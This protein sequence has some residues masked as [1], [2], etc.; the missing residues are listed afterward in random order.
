MSANNRDFNKLYREFTDVYELGELANPNDKLNVKSYIRN[1]ILIEKLQE[2]I[3]K[4]LEAQNVLDNIG[5]I[6]KL[7]D[8]LRDMS[9]QNLALERT[10]GI[11]RKSRKKDNQENITDYWNALMSKARDYLD[12]VVIR[13]Y[14]PE[15]QVMVGRVLP[16][17]DHTSFRAEFQCSQC[18]K[19]IYVGRKERDVFFDI[20]ESDREWRR[21]YP[22]EIEKP[23][24]RGLIKEVENEIVIGEL[25]VTKDEEA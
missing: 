13:V 3:D 11:D 18:S 19:P 7:Q 20:P 6:K 1:Q 17:H 16:V 9:E 4:E 24:S 10:L 5:S 14:C 23:R 12:S 8:S 21:K 25:D 15:C 2:A 22:V